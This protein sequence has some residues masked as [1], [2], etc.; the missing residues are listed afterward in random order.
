MLD[1]SRKSDPSDPAL[2]I[3]L[4]IEFDTANSDHSFTL[5]Q[6][7]VYNWGPFRGLHRPSLILQELPSSDQ[8]A[9]ERR[10]WSMR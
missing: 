9:A 1:R 7:E 4:E 8:R 2:D 6:L 3:D 10:P 5:S